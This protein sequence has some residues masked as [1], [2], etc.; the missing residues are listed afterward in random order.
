MSNESLGSEDS[1][2]KSALESLTEMLEEMLTEAL[3]EEVPAQEPKGL[4][5]DDVSVPLHIWKDLRDISHETERVYRY[6]HGELTLKDPVALWIS[7]SNSHYVV[8]ADGSTVYV[9]PG[10]EVLS[11]KARPGADH[12][13]FG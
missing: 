8:L 3:E 7:D 13:S 6:I 9:R 12:I 5:F 11:W 2:G 10:W 1:L 4:K